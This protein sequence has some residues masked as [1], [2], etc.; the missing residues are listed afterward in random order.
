MSGHWWSGPALS[1]GL[2]RPLF[3]ATHE[4]GACRG[5]WVC[6]AM[7]PAVDVVSIG[8]VSDDGCGDRGRGLSGSRKGDDGAGIKPTATHSPR[9]ASP[10]VSTSAC[11][12]RRRRR[13]PASSCF[14]QH[15]V[16]SGIGGGATRRSCTC[17]G[18]GVPVHRHTVLRVPEG[19]TTISS[20]T[21]GVSSVISTISGS[22]SSSRGSTDTSTSTDAGGNGVYRRWLDDPC[23]REPQIQLLCAG[24]LHGHSEPKGRLLF[25]LDEQ[26]PL[27][28]PLGL[29][30]P[31][32]SPHR[33]ANTLP[34]VPC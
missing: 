13:H 11:R 33:R 26:P 32:R 6:R 2:S 8:A 27:Q 15:D 14:T 12:G 23:S 31:H 25:R 24:A 7:L 3:A 28:R 21:I 9:R 18:G 10:S 34:S 17:T 16:S 20:T 1:L 4:R 19:A 22:G 30:Q 5:R 29:P